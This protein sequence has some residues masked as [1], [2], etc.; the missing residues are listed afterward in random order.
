MQKGFCIKQALNRGLVSQPL[1]IPNRILNNS[2]KVN[3]N[4][5]QIVKKKKGIRDILG[6]DIKSPAAPLSAPSPV[7]FF[8][9][10]M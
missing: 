3:R 4:G 2:K 10:L 1:A 7:V 6:D 9:N 8:C 5:A